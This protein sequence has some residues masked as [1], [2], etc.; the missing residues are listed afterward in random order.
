[1]IFISVDFPAPFAPTM[2]MRSRSLMWRDTALK[3]YV[4]LYCLDML[5]REINVEPE[6]LGFRDP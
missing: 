3:R 2:A 1:M 5:F 6:G 4:P